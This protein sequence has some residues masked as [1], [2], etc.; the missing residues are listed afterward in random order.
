MPAEAQTALPKAEEQSGHCAGPASAKGPNLA[1]ARPRAAPRPR[2]TRSAQQAAA[3]TDAQQQQQQQQQ[4]APDDGQ[5]R[6]M[7]MMQEA[8]VTP[9]EMEEG[10]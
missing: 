1:R 6:Y 3:K 9:E 10:L 7:R 8:G 2:A 5:N 4:P